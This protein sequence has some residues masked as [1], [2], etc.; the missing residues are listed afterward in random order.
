MFGGSFEV[1]WV[2][3]RQFKGGFPN[4]DLEIR[5]L[6]PNW[7]WLEMAIFDRFFVAYSRDGSSSGL[8]FF[9]GFI[10]D[11]IFCPGIMVCLVIESRDF[12]RDKKVCCTPF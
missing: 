1:F 11:S 8:Q 4:E 3:L 5:G 10:H 6:D 9:A 2:R 12:R 7:F